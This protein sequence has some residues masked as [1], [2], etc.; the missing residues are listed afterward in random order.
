MANGIYMEGPY[1]AH[2][3]HSQRVQQVVEVSSGTEKRLRD[4]RNLKEE[5][6]SL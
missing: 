2:M 4:C 3:L 1:Q 6:L 5:I